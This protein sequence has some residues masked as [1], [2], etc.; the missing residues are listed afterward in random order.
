MTRLDEKSWMTARATTVELRRQFRRSRRALTIT[1]QS[2][3]ANAVTRA[4]INSGLLLSAS[5][6]GI[7]FAQH[8]DGELDTLPLLSRLW[9]FSKIV[10]CPVIGPRR[11]MGLW[12]VTP[13]SRLITNRYGIPEPC[14]HGQDAARFLNPL[15]M[16]VLFMPLV[17]FDDQGTRLGMGAG[18]YDRYLGRLPSSLRPLVIGLAHEV[19]RAANTLERRPWDIPLDGVVTD[20]G[21]QPFSSR[22]KVSASSDRGAPINSLTS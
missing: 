20:A 1:E 7:Y 15:R 11:S 17:A 18:Y 22:A 3:H 10:G 14:T 16:S 2:S 8:E 4:V 12:Q 19:Q 21:W 5:S 9:S 6:C 13:D